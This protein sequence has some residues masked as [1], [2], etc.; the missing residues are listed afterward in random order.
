MPE[1]TQP[2]EPVD[3][4]IVPTP[5]PA[6][7][8]P[9]VEPPAADYDERGVPTLDH[10]RDKI[11]GRYATSLGATELA[12]AAAG[13]AVT[14]VAEQEAERAEKAKAK[15]EEIRRSLGG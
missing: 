15:L 1:P 2:N 8:M 14:S 10:V 7:Q 11:E 13:D 4:E 6:P 12:E 5:A 9:V 3:A